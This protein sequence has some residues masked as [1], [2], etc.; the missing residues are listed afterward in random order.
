MNKNVAD[1]LKNMSRQKQLVFTLLAAERY[2][3]CYKL[4]SEKE[5]FG[6]YVYILQALKMIDDIVL[7][8]S[9]KNEEMIALAEKI[10]ENTPD[11]DDFGSVGSSLALNVAVIVYEGL[12]LVIDFQERRLDDISTMCTDSVD[13]VILE[14]E[15][16]D[17]RDFEAINHHYL[18]KEEIRIQEDIISYL[19]K[20]PDISSSD[21]ASLRLLQEDRKF[22]QLDLESI[23]YAE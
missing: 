22:N 19:N 8:V 11:I 7:G 17:S 23:L 9:G 12:H 16:Y 15:E 20:L 1:I 2:A 6:D 13:F 18:M 10:E 4:F 3:P 21:I 14:I 5:D